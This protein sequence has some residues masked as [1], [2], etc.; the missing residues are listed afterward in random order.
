VFQPADGVGRFAC[1]TPQVLSL[2]A[3]DTALDVWR[4]VRMEDVRNKSVAL[5]EL[6]LWL[7]RT[8]CAS[9][10]IG[11]GCSPDEELTLVS[12]SDPGACNL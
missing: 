2:A 1:G 8:R 12:P 3:L 7:V 11:G 5:C 9:F 4:D 6:F 10:C